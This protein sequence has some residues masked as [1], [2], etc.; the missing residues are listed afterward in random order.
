MK[1]NNN[2]EFTCWWWKNHQA[3]TFVI[4][5][6]AARSNIRESTGAISIFEQYDR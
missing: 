3:I 6:I 2:T 4:G 1:V 5:N